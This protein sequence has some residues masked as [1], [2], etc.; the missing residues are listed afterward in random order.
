[1]K[2]FA[3]RAA[4]DLGTNALTRRVEARLARGEVLVDLTE[5]NPTRCAF[6]AAET[7]A[8]E[9]YAR[10]AGDARVARYAPDPRGKL[11]AREAVA[12]Y[13]A[14][15][16]ARVDPAHVVLC[17]GTGEGYA[18]LFRLLADP[19][20]AV[21]VPRP[22]YPLFD[23]L[24]GLEGVETR[25]YPLAPGVDGAWRI[26]FDALAGAL[27][28][29]VRAVLAVHPNNPTGSFV[30]PADAARLGAVCAERGVAL[31]AD[32]VFLD[33]AAPGAEALARTSL[34]GDAGAG[35]RFALSGVS[36]LA[37]MPQAKLAWI[38]AAGPREL[39]DEALARLEVIADTYLSVPEAGQVLLPHVLRESEPV[40]CEIRA[41]IALNRAALERALHALPGVR[42]LRAQ[43][44]W[45]AV[46]Q[47]ERAR[48]GEE[49]LALARVDAGVL[50]HPGFFFDFDDE[51]DAAHLVVALLLPAGVFADG[52]E[53]LVR[54]LA[55]LPGAS[56]AG[57]L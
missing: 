36:K 44:G 10:L 39:R 5:S 40:R 53:R 19:G 7:L 30:S 38:A 50:V 45:Y 46:L 8:R 20:D 1:V 49:A 13:Y 17:A 2:A 47:I 28:A 56:R 25:A 9:A 24:A 23:F 51:P 3:R 55:V 12:E 26:D 31:V 15:R 14:A 54:G 11:E 48:E 37:G 29:S 57:K 32:E 4:W 21:L 43:G 22:S 18:H 52:V 41:R 35:L 27:D 34:A 6:A 16:G 33:Y 42:A